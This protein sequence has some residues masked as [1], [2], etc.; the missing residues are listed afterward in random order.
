MKFKIFS[1]TLL[2]IILISPALIWKKNQLPK[3]PDV[4]FTT[5][6][7]KKIEL[8][9]LQGKAVIITFWATDCKSC[10]EEVPHLISLYDKYHSQGLEI[11]AIAMSYDLPNHVVEMTI[12]I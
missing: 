8:K 3:A 4:S 11:I 10:I 9:S 2:M 1:F 6:K 12:A 7:N 5:I